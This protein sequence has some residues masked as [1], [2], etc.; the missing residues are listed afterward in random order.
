MMDKHQLIHKFTPN[1]DNLILILHEL[2]NNHPQHYLEEED[3]LAVSDYLNI[4]KSQV[5]GVVTYYSMFSL[6]PRGKYIIRLCKSPV[7]ELEEGARIEKAITG[8]LGIKAGE[9]TSDG[10]FTLEYTICLGHC[11]KSPVVMIN[12]DV[13]GDLKPEKLPEILSEYK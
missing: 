11:D 9:T 1:A 4:T 13:Y 10:L 3:L 7:C 5:Y 8:K 2:Q 6:K 12:E